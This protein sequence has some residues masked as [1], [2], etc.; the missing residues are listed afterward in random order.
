MKDP[1]DHRVCFVGDSFV[2]GTCDPEYRGWFGR[3]ASASRARGCDVT[4]YNL[5]VRRDTSRDVRAR[6]EAECAARLPAGCSPYAVFSFGAN[7]MT[8]E[9]GR[10]RVA[11]SESVA[12]LAAVIGS[13]REKYAVLV[14]GP[15]PVG[16][17]SQDERILNLC[18][19]YEATS[20]ALG[21]PYLPVAARLAEHPVWRSEVAAND[22]SH[23]GAAGYEL[24]A[25]LVLAWPS[26]WFRPAA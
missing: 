4:A 16:D 23:P 8:M 25:S 19:R 21:I 1:A 9:Q 10:L 18:A 2:Q 12:N 22:G 13:A 3:V 11:E 7:D 20:A 14:V 24:I 26:W 17:P 6:W 5:G 15:L